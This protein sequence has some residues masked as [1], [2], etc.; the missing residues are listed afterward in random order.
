MLTNLGALLPLARYRVAGRS[1]TPG[2]VEGERVLVNKAAYWFARPRPDDVVVLRDPRDP[3][4]L[5]IKRIERAAGVDE[6][7]VAGDNADASTDSRVFGPVAREAIVGKVWL[8][9]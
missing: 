2:L 5:L 3:Q 9:Y 8:R 7:L 1:M 6:W 4:R